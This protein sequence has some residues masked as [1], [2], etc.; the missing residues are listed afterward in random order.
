M[1][2]AMIGGM[3]PYHKVL[4]TNENEFHQELN[5]VIDETVLLDCMKPG[6]YKTFISK[7]DELKRQKENEVLKVSF[8]NENWLMCLQ[9]CNNLSN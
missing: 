8:G 3:L 5:Y 4:E 6:E 1:I 2:S 7:F 9:A